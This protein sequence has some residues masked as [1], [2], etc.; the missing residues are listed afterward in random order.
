M[1][2]GTILFY[3]IVGAIV[4]VLGKFVAPGSRDNIPF[5]LTIICGIGGMLLGDVIYRSFGGDG[6]PG[7]DWTQGLVAVLTSA[8]LV[9][10]AATITGR[11]RSKA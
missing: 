11:S 3:L 1:D 6:S 8:V 4:G 9:M 5:W 2:L 10:A 7:L